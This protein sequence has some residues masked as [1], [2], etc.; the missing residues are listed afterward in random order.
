[1]WT[2]KKMPGQWSQEGKRG[3]NVDDDD[4]DGKEE[5]IK[6]TAAPR[7]SGKL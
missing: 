5:G 3:T 1:M 4:D 2:E 7:Q 6:A